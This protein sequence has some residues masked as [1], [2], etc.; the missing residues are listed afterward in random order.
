[1]PVFGVSV[2]GGENDPIG[3]GAVDGGGGALGEGGAP[4]GGVEAQHSVAG[5]AVGV[6]LWAGVGEL[7]CAC[8]AIGA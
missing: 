8:V 2:R 6:A 1:M 7:A 4:D 3:V 5:G